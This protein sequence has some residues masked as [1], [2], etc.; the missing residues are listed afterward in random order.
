MRPFDMPALS[1]EQQL[2]RLKQR[3][4]HVDLSLTARKNKSV[5][6]FPPLISSAGMLGRSRQHLRHGARLSD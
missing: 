3:G 2:E 6:F 4:L 1:V 5:T